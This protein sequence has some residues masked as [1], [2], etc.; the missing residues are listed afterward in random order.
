MFIFDHP[1]HGLPRQVR[2][3]LRIRPQQHCGQVIYMR[4]PLRAASNVPLNY[5]QFIR[6]RQRQGIIRAVM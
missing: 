5:R 4:G 6:L 2:R 3:Q 1:R